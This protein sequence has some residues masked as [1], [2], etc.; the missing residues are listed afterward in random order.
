M[1]GVYHPDTCRP[2]EPVPYIAF[3]ET[4]DPGVPYETGGPGPPSELTPDD[5][6]PGDLDATTES[7]NFF[8]PHSRAKP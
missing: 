4:G 7:W 2:S 5:L 8:A 3:H 1:A 6:T